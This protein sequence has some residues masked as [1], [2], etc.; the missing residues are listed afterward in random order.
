MSL[1][2]HIPNPARRRVVALWVLCL[3]A[4]PLQSAVAET[5]SDSERL[6]RLERAVE[7]L[8]KRNAELEQEVRSLKKQKPSSPPVLSE[9]KRSRFVSDTKSYAEKKEAVEEKNPVYVVPGASEITFTLGGL[10][11]TQFEAGD[12]SA[13]EGRFG[14][15]AID[16]RFRLRRL[17]IN[18]TGEFTE[19][20]D[21]KLEGEF[22][23]SDTTL[24]VRDATGKTLASN[25]TRTSFGGLDLFANFHQFPEFQIKIG[26]YK[27][28]FGLEQISSDAKLFTL[29][30]SQVT[31]A[32]TAERQIGVQIWGKPFTNVF[33]E[34]KDLLTYYAGIFNGTGRNISVNDN[35]QYMYAGRLELQPW[36][37]K[38]SD[39][40]AWL[41]FGGNALSSRDASGTVLSSA[42]NLRVNS[43]GSLSSFV[44][45]SAATR[46]AYGFDATFHLGPFDFIAE[47]LSERIEPRTAPGFA[48]FR[49][50]GY[51]VQGTY[52]IV[53]EKLQLFTK[54]ESFNPGQIAN[55]DIQSITGGV[56][57]YIH[58]DD[59]KLLAHYIHTW[60]DFRKTNP[61]LGS[62][63]FDEIILRLQLLF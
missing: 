37:G 4:L 35:D 34:Q 38:I 61:A 43:D 45:P 7:L 21:F 57:Y 44:A 32:L 11:Q 10:L 47:Y 42:G 8:Q 41:R 15:G 48:A 31:S 33:P 14:S 13:F 52:F 27:A 59:I 23:Q 62:D 28:P 19:Q 36:K 39:A 46:E 1:P 25:S 20:F 30:R 16:D 56:N 53:P 29:E 2:S 50:D 12:V 63:E 6:E 55:D 3:V 54:Y 18:V 9:E 17:R 51:Y 22:A 58:C 60:S 26:Q 40:E 5:K 49:A 24:T